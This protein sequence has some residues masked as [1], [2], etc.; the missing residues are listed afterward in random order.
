MGRSSFGPPSHFDVS[1]NLRLLS[2]FTEKYLDLFF[3]LFERVAHSRAWPDADRTLMLQCVFTGKAQEAYSSLSAI[4]NTDYVKVN[5]DYVK[6]KTAVLQ[7]YVLVPEA[8]RQRFRTLKR[9]DKL[10]HVFTFWGVPYERLEAEEQFKLFFNQQILRVLETTSLLLNLNVFHVDQTKQV[11]SVI[12]VRE[13]D[14]GRTNVPFPDAQKFSKRFALAGSVSHVRPV[15]QGEKLAPPIVPNYSPFITSGYVSVLGSGVQVPIKILRDTG[16]S[17]LFVLEYVLPFSSETD[18]ETSVLIQGMG[19]TTLSV[20]L[21]KVELISDLVQG[22]VTL[23]VRPFL[24]VDG[25]HV[26]LGNNLAGSRVWRDV[27]Q[28]VVSNSLSCVEANNE[29]I[30]SYPEVF[31]ACAVTRAMS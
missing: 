4:D 22:E 26:L 1:R 29:S 11:K 31:S 8:Y 13:S 21:H 14:T 23:G 2:K 12:I 10:S 27:P 16:A 30:Q 7:A 19:L 17:E 25:V 3:Y 20:P 24:P 6:V 5:T 15:A 28:L 18:T 9:G